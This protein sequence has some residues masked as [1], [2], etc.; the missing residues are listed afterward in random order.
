MLNVCSRTCRLTFWEVEV[1]TK[2]PVCGR[3]S[4]REAMT[5]QGTMSYH[6]VAGTNVVGVKDPAKTTMAGKEPIIALRK[7]LEVTREGILPSSVVSRRSFDEHHG[8]ALL[9]SLAR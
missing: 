7:M 1:T 5:S 9:G 8:A 4:D 3:D 6:H 2:R